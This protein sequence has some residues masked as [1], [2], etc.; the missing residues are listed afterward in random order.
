[1]VSGDVAVIPGNVEHEGFFRRTPRSS[2]SLH[3]LAKIS[4]Q[5]TCRPTCARRSQCE[6]RRARARKGFTVCLSALKDAHDQT[7]TAASEHSFV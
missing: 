6:R 5:A 7:G 1:M 3:R 2:I 4:S